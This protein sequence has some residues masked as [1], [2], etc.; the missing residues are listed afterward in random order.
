VHAG[1]SDLQAAAAALRSRLPEPLHALA[2][3]AYN[4][5]WSWTPGGPELLAS[6]DPRRWELCL[7]NPVRLIEEV[8]P[9][10]WQRLAGDQD[11]LDRLKA[12][13]RAISERL[14]EPLLGEPVTEDRPAAFF[15]AEFA[16]HKSL[17]V[18]SGGL[19]VLAGDILKEASDMGLPLVAVGLM[20][21]HGYFRQR[22]DASGWQHEYWVETDPDRVP[23]ALVTGGDGVPVTVTV[24]ISER[25]IVAQIWRVDVGRVPLLLLD[26]DREENELT[27][28]WITSRLYVGDPGM[29]LGQY[30]LL[31]IGGVRALRALG[32]DPGVVHLNEGHAALATLELARGEL[33]GGAGTLDDAFEAVRRRTVFTTH[34]PVPAGN[35]TY[36]AAQ[37]AEMLDGISRELNV[38]PWTLVC[39]GRTHTDEDAEPF[40]VTQFALRASRIA[41][42][43]SARH[44]E[45]AREMWRDMWPDREV[46][47][48]P[49]T[50]V[51]NGAHIP[52]WIGGPMRELLDRHLGEGWTDRAIDPATWEP[53]DSIPDEELW[54]ARREQRA[55][56]L[57]VVRERSVMDRLARGDTAEYV[58][59]AVDALDAEYLTIGFARRVATYKRLDL[60]LRDVDRAL[61]LL[62]DEERPVQLILAGKAHPKDDDGKRLVQRLFEMK[63]HLE[64]ARRVVYLDD[65]DLALG[66][67]MVRGCDVWV[68]V[69]RPPLEA[70]GTSGIKSAQNGGLQLSVLD[71]WWPEAYDGSNGWAIS[72]EV[73]LDH[74]AQDWRHAHEL[75]RLLQEE[76]VPTFY[77]RDGADLSKPWLTMVRNS[78]RTIGPE[79]G[80]RRMLR[81]YAERIYPADVAART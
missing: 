4:Y 72:G 51:T 3:I 74:G 25:E 33:D 73:D 39:R 1:S 12:L 32:V 7:G 47:D 28:R 2:D 15:C 29:R 71:G 67:S 54:A 68:N 53:L 52:T 17:P 6:V 13:E 63:S 31:G 21:R 8:H 40:G 9:D 75:Y 64:V 46:D 26:A 50:H 41:N 60:L 57:D 23:A 36:P 80:A 43:V 34:T 18:Y 5:R 59:A 62:G 22:I 79:F 49:I 58:Q 16:V 44:G 10:R 77:D 81:D 27:D 30:A 42:G 45:V 38:D 35:D 66:A 48:V 24:P 70:S 69:P 14:D 11:F 55:Q 37:M 76:V 61:K 20:Y 65:Y 56:L 19:G 78:L